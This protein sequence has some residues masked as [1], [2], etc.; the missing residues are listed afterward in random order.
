MT[1]KQKAEIWETLHESYSVIQISAKALTYEDDDVS[2]SI[3]A[4][5]LEMVAKKLMYCI[6]IL[7]STT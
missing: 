1:P 3:Y 7:D 5:S 2:P 4:T 6:S